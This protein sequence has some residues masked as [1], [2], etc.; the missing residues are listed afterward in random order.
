[1]RLNWCLLHAP[2][3]D[4]KTNLEPLIAERFISDWGLDLAMPLAIEKYITMCSLKED[5][6]L[7]VVAE[8]L[9]QALQRKTTYM[10]E[11]SYGSRYNLWDGVSVELNYYKPGS[12]GA[13][14]PSTDRHLKIS[15]LHVNRTTQAANRFELHITK[16]R[17]VHICPLEYYYYTADYPALDI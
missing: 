13:K 3:V 6:A 1:M 12:P 7:R 14:M 16:S 17:Y 4:P 2:G 15:Y 11:S 8:S 10:S 5:S 9:T